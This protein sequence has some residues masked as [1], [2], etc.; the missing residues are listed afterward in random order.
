LL[1]NQLLQQLVAQGLLTHGTQAA[2]SA[3]LSITANEA[4]TTGN[5][6]QVT[7]SNVNT[8]ANTMTVTVSATEVYP[9]L[10]TATLGNALGTS[11]TAANGLVY[12]QSPGSQQPG[13]YSQNTSS[14][15]DY[16]YPIPEAPPATGTAFTL[17]AAD[18]GGTADAANVSVSVVPDPA[19]A[20]TFT[21]TAS[22]TKSINNLTLA[23]LTA[24]APSPPPFG[25]LVTFSAPAGGALPAP[26]TV[27]LQGGATASSTPAAAATAPLLSS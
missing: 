21:L 23:M 12:L 5:V 22:W 4:G 1:I 20:T 25:L 27:T 24:A 2:P 26:G 11:A 19:P 17:A 8:S 3:A 13:L 18:F 9:G 16:T 14:G 7:I 10:T 15:P 6:I